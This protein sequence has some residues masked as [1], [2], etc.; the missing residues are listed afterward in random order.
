[1][2]KIIQLIK[3]TL[4]ILTP[5]QKKIS[6]I[7]FVLSLFGSCL[8][9]IGVSAVVPLTG[10]IVSPDKLKNNIYIRDIGFIQQLSY[11]QLVVAV[12]AVVI[13]IY[14]FK[15]LYY[16]FLS[17]IGVR[18]SCKVQREL[19]VRAMNTLFSRGYQYFLDINAGLYNQYVSGD[20]GAIFGVINNLFSLVSEVVTISMI[21]VFLC[22]TDFQL[23]V[24]I[25]LLALIS[26]IVLLRLYRYRVYSSALIMRKYGPAASQAMNEAYYGVKDVILMRKQQYFV[27]EYE[28]NCITMQNAQCKQTVATSSPPRIIEAICVT[29]IMVCIGAKIVMGHVDEGFVT[30]LAAFAVGVFRILPSLGKISSSINSLTASVPGISALRENMDEAKAFLN[31]HPELIFYTDNSKNDRS[32]ISKGNTYDFSKPSSVFSEGKFSDSLELV[33][34]SFRYKDDL[35]KI[36]DDIN[37][38]IKKGQSIALIGES[39][40][41]KSTLVDVLLGLLIPQSGKILIDG[42]ETKEDPQK[43]ADTI[44][45]VPQAVFLCDSSVKHNIAFGE[46][47]EDI[48]ERLVWEA[49]EQ[50]ELGDFIRSLPEGLNSR[51]GDK[52][53]RLS[54]GQRQR[55][56]I[57]RALY[58]RPEI[59]VLDE[60]TSALDNNTESAIMSTINRLQGKVTMIIVAHRLTTIQRCDEIYEVINTKLLRKSKEEIF[61]K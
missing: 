34:I 13:V 58:R 55:I 36:L 6:I 23:S 22:F 43:W 20:P 54:G 56:A 57:A 46:R 14:V 44:G 31:K 60:A 1:M 11:E 53:V 12:I 5:A 21:F 24:T 32:L 61:G 48:D 28:R 9:L 4:Y 16:V 10:I 18:F 25:I 29:G 40:A 2:K 17:W 41:G 19:T 45:Y 47:E 8:E 15:N 35:P 51:F 50:A 33:D 42:V 49:L 3:N 59:L 7:Y 27:Y 37:L 30:T 38:K 26:L 39:G 52:G